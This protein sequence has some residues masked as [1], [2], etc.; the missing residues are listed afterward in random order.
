[1]KKSTSKR[2]TGQLTCG[3][4]GRTF[5]SDESDALPFCS[6]RCRL[7]DLGHWLDEGY[8]LPYEGSPGD[9]PEDYL[10]EDDET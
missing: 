2:P 4:C 5:R 8:G 9:A 7:I 6:Q 3:I 10:S 1:M